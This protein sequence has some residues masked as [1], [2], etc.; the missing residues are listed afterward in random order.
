MCIDSPT[1]HDFSFTPSMSILVD[2]VNEA[3]INK[4]FERLSQGGKVLMPFNNDGF[5]AS[6]VAQRRS[7]G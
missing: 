4:V 5:N 3:E 6:L 7:A 1:K 2:C